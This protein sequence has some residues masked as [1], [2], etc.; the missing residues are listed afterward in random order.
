VHGSIWTFSGD[1]DD[2]LPRYEAMVAELPI[3]QIQLH[4]AL[5][6]DD[7]IVIV[8]TCPSEEDFRSFIAG[9]WFAE[10]RARHGMPP[11]ARIED[12]PVHLAI[13]DGRRLVTA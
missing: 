2:L 3:E 9:E 1:P 5:R 8:D 11:L 12:H 10:L 6:T 4:V 13:V 7:G